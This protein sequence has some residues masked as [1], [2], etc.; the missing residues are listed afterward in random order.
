MS[1]SDKQA[2]RRFY[3]LCRLTLPT[4]SNR[5]D[6]LLQLLHR[7]RCR[8]PLAPSL[9]LHYQL[10]R[11]PLQDRIN[12]K[13]ETFVAAHLATGHRLQ[14]D[15]LASTNRLLLEKLQLPLHFQLL[16]L[17]R[18]P[19]QKRWVK[20]WQTGISKNEKRFSL[21]WQEVFLITFVP[22]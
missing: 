4:T 20:K 11:Q 7:H 9:A 17:L 10:C 22:P 12:D 21:K 3:L 5:L 1:D 19:L 18:T 8:Q 14:G 13:V 6:N 15:S 2:G 16:Q